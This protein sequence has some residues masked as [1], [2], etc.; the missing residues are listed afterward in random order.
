MLIYA[1]LFRFVFFRT[2]RKG[3]SLTQQILPTPSSSSSLSS[4]AALAAGVANLKTSPTSTTG[5]STT[6]RHRG[7]FHL[8]IKD[9]DDDRDGIIPVKISTHKDLDDLLN[10]PIGLPPPRRNISA[11]PVNLLKDSQDCREAIDLVITHISHTDHQVAIQ[12]LLQIDVVIKDKEKKELLVPHVDNL[13]NTCSVKLNIAHNVY[14]NNSP[15]CQVELVFKLFKGIFHVLMD[16]FESGLAR[17][18]S[19][20]SLHDVFYNLLSVMTDPKVV[21]Y[22]DG[23]QLIRAINLVTLKLLECSEQTTCY[24]ALVKLLA[25]S[26]ASAAS[27][28]QSKYLELVMKCIWRQIRR[29]SPQNGPS[30]GP[31]PSMR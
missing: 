28:Q 29:L 9:D 13:I 7:E 5:A 17:T 25:E 18:A 8:D 31:N 20:K 30:N 26:C 12:N 21:Q 2:P 3:Q 10:Q 1:N 24:C 6:T 22:P 4:A 19:V 15:D 14:L 11:I 16:L 23:D 27:E